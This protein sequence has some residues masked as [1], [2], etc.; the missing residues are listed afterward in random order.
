MG[1]IFFA[2]PRLCAPKQFL[3]DLSLGTR[4]GRDPVVLSPTLRS[5]HT[6]EKTPKIPFLPLFSLRC[7]VSLSLVSPRV[8]RVKPGH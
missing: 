6:Q 8:A 7:E 3:F 2:A 4:R 1:K 5:H